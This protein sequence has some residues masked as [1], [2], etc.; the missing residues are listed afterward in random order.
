MP[1]LD[2]HQVRNR[3]ELLCHLLDINVRPK[4]ELC[5]SK[6]ALVSARRLHVGT[7]LRRAFSGL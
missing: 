6:V 4:V 7:R 2:L 3:L 1:S 5:G